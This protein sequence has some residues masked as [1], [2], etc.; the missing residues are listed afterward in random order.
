MK[1]LRLVEI[2]VIF[3]PI[4]SLNLNAIFGQCEMKSSESTCFREE[5]I[6][7]QFKWLE[8]PQFL[9]HASQLPFKSGVK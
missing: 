3:M 1:I 6:L 2:A 8:P 7:M 9:L 5:S 4:I